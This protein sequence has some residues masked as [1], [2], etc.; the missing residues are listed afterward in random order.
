MSKKPITVSDE[1]D[2]SDGGKKIKNALKDV[3]TPRVSSNSGAQDT[4]VGAVITTNTPS[5][6][7][8]RTNDNTFIIETKKEVVVNN[9]ETTNKQDFVSNYLGSGFSGFSGQDG[10]AAYSG[11][12]GLSGAAFV[13][14][15]GASGKSGVSGHS[16]TSGWSGQSGKSG[17]SGH[18][19][20]GTSGTSGWSGRSGTSG[21]TGLQGTSGYSGSSGQVGLRGIS[22]VKGTSGYS[23][24]RGPSG[25]SGLSG[26]SGL[27]GT[28]VKL[29]GSVANYTLLPLGAAAGDL[30]IVLNAGGGYSAGDGAVSNGSN[31]WSNVG[32]IQGPAGEPGVSGFSGGQGLSGVSGKSGF[33]GISGYSGAAFVGS[34]GYSGAAGTSGYSGPSNSAY[35]NFVQAGTGAVPR[36]AQN[37]MRE[38]VSVLDFGATGDGSTDDRLYIQNAFN[39]IKTRGGKLVFP[40]P[41]VKYRITQ[42][43]GSDQRSITDTADDVELYF[44]PNTEVYFDYDKNINPDPIQPDDP[45][46]AICLQGNNVS[47]TGSLLLNSNK[48]IDYYSAP[49]PQRTPYYMGV[50]IG[51]TGYRYR[52]KALGNEREGVLLNGVTCTNFNAPLVVYAAS[53]VTVEYCTVTDDTDTGI[54]IDD[55]LSNIEVRFNTVKR[56][57]DDCFFARHYYNTP[58]V[59]HG[60]YIGNLR[61]HHNT[62]TD[63]FAKSGG[64]GGFA[65]VDIHDNYFAN[66]WYAAFNIEVNTTDW[67][68]NNKRIRIHDNIIKD[69]ARNFDP[70]NTNLPAVQQAPV[71]DTTQQAGILFTTSSAS[72][73]AKRF[74]DIEIYD[75][76]IVNPGWNGIS[77]ST[78]YGVS[79]RGN[80]M[81]PGRTTKNAINYDTGGQAVR[82]ENVSLATI[83]QNEILPCLSPAI[84]FPYCYEITSDTYTSNIFVVNNAREK[85]TNALFV[86]LST[87]CATAITYQSVNPNQGIEAHN[88]VYG[89]L[90]GT[91]LVNI[92]TSGYNNT[93][94]GRQAGK[95]ISTGFQN[96]GVGNNALLNATIGTD[97]TSVG[98]GAGKDIVTGVNNVSMGSGALSGAD[99]SG[100]IAIGANSAA[101]L[102]SAYSNSI[103]IG[104]NSTVT[105]SNA[106]AIGTSATAPAN[107]IRLGDNTVTSIGGY[108][109]WSNISDI[110]HKKD[111]L[112]LDLGVEFLKSIRPVSYKLI[113]GN[114][115][116]DWGFIAQEVEQ[117]IGSRQANIIERED[118]VDGTY[119]L[120]SADL[121]AV[122]VKAVQQLT[123]RVEQ[124]ENGAKNA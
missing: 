81:I 80:R 117:A 108:Q 87:V 49:T 18:S 98:H 122:L 111:I 86:S 65:D 106:V 23:G 102:S 3:I 118:D 30:Y 48:N 113:S 21:A 12:S 36:T 85:F 50:V 96:T 35:I 83:Q 33:S 75:N 120:R 6:T 56:S 15:S 79:I 64:V 10:A 115:K 99:T 100:M 67:Y 93:L 37:K 61:I 17:W 7:I 57:F 2:L 39:Y 5:G 29:L 19:G 9:Y 14:S 77:A 16:G 90:A 104:F 107:S 62:F 58:W 94:F 54:L 24:Q 22:G 76:L 95:T 4:P 11:Y 82:L 84:N 27:N 124:L 68:D 13:G 55:C 109:N 42:G 70:T 116:E 53:D 105:G 60:D 51:G 40:T 45:P 119:R 74:E 71:A 59:A 89:Y 8:V 28:S 34:S 25:Y 26:K 66:T 73:P 101:G 114:Q 44:E 47:I 63:T 41:S 52:T 46:A 92:G 1:P 112:D 121:I 72:W 88:S 43:I 97:N 31:T 123:E 78:S 32:P 110:R 20:V 103:S 38:T 91:A 69:A